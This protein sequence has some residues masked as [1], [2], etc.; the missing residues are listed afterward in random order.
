MLK[1]HLPG[2]GFGFWYIYGI[3]HNLK[4]YKPQEELTLSGKSG[5]AVVCFLSLLKEEHQDFKF[6]LEQGEQM[7][8][9]ED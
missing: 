8:D 3:F 9:S 4:L 1:V 2:C 7:H 6:L 5:G